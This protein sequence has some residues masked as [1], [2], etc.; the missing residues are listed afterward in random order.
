[1]MPALRITGYDLGYRTAAGGLRPALHG[2]DLEIAAGETLGLVGASGSGKTSLAWSILRMLPGNAREGGGTIALGGEDLRAMTRRQL[3]ALRGGRIGMVF[4]GSLDRAQ[5]IHA[6]GRPGDGGA[7]AAPAPEQ[8][9]R[10]GGGRAIAGP[11]RAA[12]FPRHHATLPAPGSVL[13]QHRKEAAQGAALNPAVCRAAL[14]PGGRQSAPAS[15]AN[16][17]PSVPST[18]GR[19]R[20]AG[21]CTVAHAAQHGHPEPGRAGAPIGRCA[22]HPHRRPPSPTPKSALNHTPRQTEKPSNTEIVTTT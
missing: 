2:I 5:S 21:C 4:P 1:M 16:A 9:G 15:R 12:R 7:G 3:A 18:A 10:R 11:H 17:R 8:A 13:R 6:A 22:T 20:T 14:Q 19:P